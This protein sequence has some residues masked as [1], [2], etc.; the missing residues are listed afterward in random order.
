MKKIFLSVLIL[1]MSMILFSPNVH[2]EGDPG[3]MVYAFDGTESTHSMSFTEESYVRMIVEETTVYEGYYVYTG[4]AQTVGLYQTYVDLNGHINVSFDGNNLIRTTSGNGI[5]FESEVVVYVIVSN[6]PDDYR[7]WSYT[8]SSVEH[9]IDTLDLNRTLFYISNSLIYNKG[10]TLDS[11]YTIFDHRLTNNTLT[12]ET[13]DYTIFYDFSDGTMGNEISTT[14]VVEA[15]EPVYSPIYTIEYIEGDYPFTGEGYHG[16]LEVEGLYS[17]ADIRDLAIGN[18]PFIISYEIN[19]FEPSTKTGFDIADMFIEDGIIKY[20]HDSLG[21]ID[22]IWVTPGKLH[23]GIDADPTWGF[24]TLFEDM[25]LYMSY[26]YRVPGI[27]G[28]GAFVTNVDAPIAEGQIRA[29]IVAFDE[30]DGDITDQITKTTDTYTANMN[31]VGEWTIVYSVQDSSENTVTFT[32]TVFVRDIVAPTID[33][34]E[35]DEITVSYLDNHNPLTYHSNFTITDNYYDLEDLE[36]TVDV[37]TFDGAPSTDGTPKTSTITY[38]VEDPS[39]NTISAEMTVNVID[40]VDPVITGPD[41]FTTTISSG[42]TLGTI[43]TQYTAADEIDGSRTNY[44]TVVSN[45][46]TANKNVAGTYEIV[47]QVTDLSGN[48][49]TKTIEVTVTDDVVPVFYITRAFISVAESITLTLED[50]IRVLY[51]TGQIDSIEGYTL[52]SSTYFGNELEEG[53]YSVKLTNGVDQLTTFIN[54]DASAPVIFA[55]Q[56]NSSG[57][58]FVSNIFVNRNQTATQPENPV[59]EGYRFEGWYR[60]SMFITP[61]EW[62]NAITDDIILYAKWVPVQAQNNYAVQIAMYSAMVLIVIGLAVFIKKKAR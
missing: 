55:I 48:I 11:D 19:D 58:S 13:I 6:S 4:D 61:M 49:G 53:I 3:F 43:L 57:G 38:T 35:F 36:I 41:D 18:E 30:S 28:T 56:F 32:V 23:I 26:I 7:Y 12:I 31:T 24:E 46:F 62:N 9:E 44:I 51:I 16:Y 27:T 39:G 5:I 29:S 59:R 50:I 37:G 40:D 17:L 14:L 33:L 52:V 15:A 10:V 34:G 54:V 45:T 22:L 25:P 1:A 21:E 2:A 8:T 42:L 20:N 60:D 47:I